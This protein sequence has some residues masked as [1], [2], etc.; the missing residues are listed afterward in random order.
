MSDGQSSEG[1]VI[2]VERWHTQA[3]QPAAT[4]SSPPLT[5]TFLTP[6]FFLF[7]SRPE[8]KP[9]MS[10]SQ[11]GEPQIITVERWHTQPPSPPLPPPIPPPLPPPF[12]V[13]A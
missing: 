8:V 6:F 11:P 12:L 4:P 10:E 5:P 9:P 1:Q 7:C 3:L 13:Q 2:T